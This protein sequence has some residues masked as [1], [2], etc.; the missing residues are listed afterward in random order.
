MYRFLLIG[1]VLGVLG[2]PS[3]SLAQNRERIKVTN[4]RI[5]LPNGPSGDPSRRGIYKTGQ[6]APV[7]AD[8]ECVKDTEETLLFTAEVLDADEIMTQG[9]VEIP[10]MVQGERRTAAELGRIPYLKASFN[11]ASVN[12]R[13]TGKD[14]GRTYADTNSRTTEG[15]TTGSYLILSIGGNLNSLRL[16]NRESGDGDV[17]SSKDLRNGWIGTSQILEIGLMPDHWIGYSA[18]DLMILN[19]GSNRA[20]WEELAAPQ[21]E[22]RRKAV[23]EWVRR[24]GRLIVGLGTNVDA[25]VNIREFKDLLPVNVPAAGKVNVSKLLMEWLVNVRQE[26]NVRLFYN[27]GP[28]EFASAIIEP[29]TD[30]AAKPLLQDFVE[31]NGPRGAQRRPL[32]VQGVC[33]TGR[34]TVFAFDLDRSPFVD[35]NQ[36]SAFWENTLA[37]CGYQIPEFGQEL[38]SYSR[39]Y[40]EFPN[41]LQGNLDFFE[42]V[43]VVSFGW[44]AL[45]ILL[46]ILLI[47]PIDYFFLKKVVK[48][49]E[50]TWVTFPIIVIGVSTAAYFTAY[51]IKGQDLKTNKI[52]VVDYDLHTGRIDG[53]SWFTLFSP[54]I[55]KYNLSIE[56]AVND[57]VSSDP[58]WAIGKSPEAALNS[59][60]TWSSPTDS[61][62]YGGGSARLLTKKYEFQS[63]VDPTDPNRDLYANSLNGVPIQVWT[64]KSFAARWTAN[65]D[66]KHPPVIANL[67]T[68]RGADKDILLTG[69]ITN[70]LP[71]EDFSDIGL[72]WR[73]KVF[74]LLD[75]PKG[76]SKPVTLSTASGVGDAVTTKEFK[77]WLNDRD[78]RYKGAQPYLPLNNS[79]RGSFDSGTTSNPNFRLWQLLF[80]ETSNDT[81]I[82]SGQP[83]NISLRDLDQ[84]WRVGP[85]HGEQAILVLRVPTREGLAESM[86]ESPLSPS[87]LWIG[88][89]PSDM[90]A[91]PS[92]PG[93]LRQETYIR[94]F[95]PVKTPK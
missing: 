87:R 59:V 90:K 18:V 76:V 63:T 41:A 82:R 68:G 74:Q 95:I 5:G 48:R 26:N 83:K 69:T 47:G 66:E 8:L 35:F 80:H 38:Q 86:A 42:G 75:L 71:V 57:G 2:G 23:A 1:L 34:V 65:V 19:T 30:R 10:T 3:V 14:S 33:G 85:D 4:I 77:T 16:Q 40:D 9:S 91:R 25:F 36:R 17:N 81:E 13:I 43:P 60:V 93:T 45:F 20:F 61:Y 28:G 37:Q 79:G 27:N 58:V 46:Y 92:N 49:L 84:S 15:M 64:T 70:M 44:V 88:A 31:E 11:Y 29:R 51:A 94:V 24:G 12:V 39:N 73:G 56:P 21:H 32:A 52:D 22:K 89:N 6:W 72:V 53:H 50:W 54:R 67:T 7:Y 62:R 78:G 55:Q